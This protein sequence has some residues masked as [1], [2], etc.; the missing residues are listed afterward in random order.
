MFYNIVFTTNK[1]VKYWVLIYGRVLGEFGCSSCFQVTVVCS[2]CPVNILVK[3]TSVTGKSA[4]K[5][6]S[7]VSSSPEDIKQDKTAAAKKKE[8]D[9]KEVDKLPSCTGCRILISDDIRYMIISD[10]H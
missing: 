10:E 8:D 7:R 4:R 9:K 6:N 2:H 3:G 1:Q 5:S